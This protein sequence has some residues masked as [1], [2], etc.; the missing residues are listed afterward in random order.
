MN[1]YKILEHS[2]QN[3][4]FSLLVNDSKYKLNIPD[5]QRSVDKVHKNTI[6]NYQE[7]HY[8]NTG[9]YLFLGQITIVELNDVFYLIDGQHRYVAYKELYKIHPDRIMDICVE[10]IKIDK[11]CGIDNLFRVINSSK[12]NK[13]HE[14]TTNEYKLLNDVVKKF[15][16][17]F[18]SY[19][20]Y[21]SKP[22]K[23]NMNIDHLYDHLH[24]SEII[25]KCGF[26]NSEELLAEIININT[27][28]SS[29]SNE[30]FSKFGVK[31]IEKTKDIIHTKHTNALYLS[32]Y[33]NYEWVYRMIDVITCKN[34]IDPKTSKKTKISYAD[35]PHY[36]DG[37][38]AKI[39]KKLRGLVWNKT[40]GKQ[41][42]GHCFMCKSEIS[43]DEFECGHVVSVFRGGQNAL[44]NL[45]AICRTCNNEMGTENL[46]EYK[47]RYILKSS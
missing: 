40:N 10:I 30:Q 21:T 44:D 35:I 8:K 36:A 23:P 29:L 2:K 43:Y 18:K 16:A 4:N 46:L 28:Y 37:V 15:E 6:V 34:T 24:K 39:P 17:K 13:I 14:S 45:Y 1:K 11:E 22:R 32:L 12:P 31:N 41:L 33:G 25:E 27:F 9:Q 26:T 38:R 19:V 3:I 20:K 42:D 47:K 7:Y 5:I